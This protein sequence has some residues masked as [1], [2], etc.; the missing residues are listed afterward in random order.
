MKQKL[1]Q[2]LLTM[3]KDDEGREILKKLRIEK[4]TD[5]KERDYED[6]AYLYDV[7]KKILH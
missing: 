6:V 1:L 3:Q 5:I 7:V 2:V 4:F